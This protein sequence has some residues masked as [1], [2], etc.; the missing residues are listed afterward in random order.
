M[1]S[2]G[3]N[4]EKIL[5]LGSVYLLHFDR[6]YH[7]ARHYVGFTHD[8]GRRIVRHQNGRGS[9]LIQAVV[10]AGIKFKV[11]RVWRNVTV[12]FERRIHKMQKK[13][14][15][16]LC[17]GRGKEPRPAPPRLADYHEVEDL[18]PENLEYDGHWEYQPRPLGEPWQEHPGQ[19]E[20]LGELG[21]EFAREHGFLAPGVDRQ[22]G[23]KD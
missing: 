23:T 13:F 2:K 21:A 15:C 22:T 10:E 8:I 1:R 16:P 7:H 3:T 6:P 17:V 4:R 11:A 5:R 18:Y 9:P 19:P 20:M 14:L 12:R